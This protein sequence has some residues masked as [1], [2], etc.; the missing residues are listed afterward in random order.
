MIIGTSEQ[1]KRRPPTI[2]QT[3]KLA[4]TGVSLLGSQA[5]PLILRRTTDIQR[6]VV[7]NS[8]W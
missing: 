5:L 3:I 8:S 4:K 7:S 2:F 6:V 1:I